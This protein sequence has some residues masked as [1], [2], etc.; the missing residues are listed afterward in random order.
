MNKL[1]LIFIILLTACASAPPLS[2]QAKKVRQINLDQKSECKFIQVV[3]YNDRIDSMGKNAT[4]MKAIGTNNIR[5]LAA[6]AGANAFLLTKEHAEWFLGQISYEAE[7]F[8]CPF[9]K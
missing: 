5:N 7:T 2:E 6:E 3:Q 9:N 1:S 8:L 4:V